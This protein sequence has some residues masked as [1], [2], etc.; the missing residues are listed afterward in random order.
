VNRRHVLQVFRK[1]G[2]EILRDRRTLFVNVLLPFLLLPLMTLFGLQ[3]WQLTRLQKEEPSLVLAVG[4]PQ[5]V[6]DEFGP[7]RVGTPGADRGEEDAEAAASAIAAHAADP[8]AAAEL[9]MGANALW[10]AKRFGA[11]VPP[12][13]EV[14]ACLRRLHAAAALVRLGDHEDVQRYALLVD[15]ADRH[16]AEVTSAVNAALEH[17]RQRLISERLERARQPPSIAQPL[18]VSVV[19]VAPVAEAVRTQLS[20]LLPLMLVIFAANGAFIPALDLLAGERERGTLE[21]LLSLPVRRRDIFL[22]KLLVTCVAAV[23]TVALN[24]L[25]IGISVAIATHSL[26]AVSGLRGGGIDFSGLLS[27]GALALVLCFLAL[28]PLTITLAATAL[29]VTGLASS[30]KEA[31]NY[32]TPFYLVVMLSAMVCMVPGTRAN[33]LLDLVPVVGPALALKDCLQGERLPWLHLGLATAASA[34]MA[35][36]VVAWATRLLE[37]ERFRYPGLV[38][39]GWGRFRVWGQGPS[40]PGGLEAM[41]VYAIFMGTLLS[42]SGLLP[43]SNALAYVSVPLI[44]GGLIALLH[45]WLGAYSVADTLSFRRPSARAIAAALGLVPCALVACLGLNGLQQWLAQRMGFHGAGPGAELIE[46][47]VRELGAQGGPALQLLAIAIVPGIC[48]ELFFRGTMLSGLKR[49][50]GPVGAV[51]LS[52]F[53]FAAS[54]GS[55]DRFLP[56]AMLGLVLGAMALRTGSIVPGMVLHAGYNSTILAIELWGDRIWQ[57]LLEHCP[58]LARALHA[59]G[60]GP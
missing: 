1:D 57:A 55:P 27:M 23:T 60:H 33:V 11:S 50:I 28:L 49:S 20:N 14:L 53:L 18:Q 44:A 41:G 9:T 21:S 47:I 31:Q 7:K 2:I 58:S 19:G 51:V 8:A 36:V 17:E 35:W 22:G 10:A 3:V 6:L 12:G 52:S 15:D 54:H 43:S 48:E 45:T 42:L 13:P 38:R 29:A 30:A 4:V 56:Q 26:S 32:I 16:S 46:R 34:A 5:G 37:D 39:A 40:S 59:S 24:I 25:S